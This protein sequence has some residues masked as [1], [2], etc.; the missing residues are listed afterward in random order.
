MRATT[1]Q[2]Q[3]PEPADVRIRNCAANSCQSAYGPIP[4]TSALP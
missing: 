2:D 1:G 3:D 4:A